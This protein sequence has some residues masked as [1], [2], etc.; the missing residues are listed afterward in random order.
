MNTNN[1]R[2]I[3]SLGR[4]AETKAI[5]DG[6]QRVANISIATSRR[7]KDRNGEWQDATDWHRAV[8][9]NPHEKL[10]PK[11]RKGAK[12]ILDGRLQTRSWDGKDGEKRYATEVI[13]NSRD[14]MVLALAGNGGQ[15][16]KQ[17]D[18]GGYPF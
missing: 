11:L 10:E 3:G 13:C 8:I 1:V 5:G 18:S 17:S 16:A 14:V 6:T 2:L 12:V 15:A 7:V 4:D 9:W